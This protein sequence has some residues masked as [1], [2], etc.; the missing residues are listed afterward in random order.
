MYSTEKL[1]IAVSLKAC[2]Q[3]AT[4][5]E[6]H[7]DISSHSYPCPSLDHPSLSGTKTLKIPAWF[8]IGCPKYAIFLKKI[9]N[10]CTKS[11]LCNTN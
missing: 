10:S 8:V 3:G 1:D 11:N 2:W 6:Q 5:P 7:K 9:F 4:A